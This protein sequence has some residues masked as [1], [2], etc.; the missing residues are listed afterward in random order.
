MTNTRTLLPECKKHLSIII[1]L[2]MNIIPFSLTAEP[3]QNTSPLSEVFSCLKEQ[4]KGL[5]SAHRG[6]GLDLKL[7]E[8]SL[9]AFTQIDSN[10]I[11]MAETDIAQSKEGVLFLH[12]DDTLDRTTTAKG[13]VAD[14]SWSEIK[15]SYLKLD[16]GE[17]TSYSPVTLDELLSSLPSNIIMQLDIKKG[18][19]LH[20]VIEKVITHNVEKQVVFLLFNNRDIEKLLTR[21]PNATITTVIDSRARLAELQRLGAKPQQLH[22]IS[23]ASDTPPAMWKTL[24]QKGITIVASVFPFEEAEMKNSG[25]L[26]KVPYEA[27]FNAGATIIVTNYPK[28]AK[29]IY[30]P[31]AAC[32]CT[33]IDN[34]SL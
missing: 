27:L 13:V 26:S 7:P 6:G 8:N 5:Y 31:D 33:C 24:K 21:L 14:V 1:L 30:S 15:R 20:R 16:N 12:H 2:C 28:Q 22:A 29:K 11:Y 19:D 3:L 32:D 4:R 18:V 9:N 10:S 25:Q 17:V 34:N 23:Y